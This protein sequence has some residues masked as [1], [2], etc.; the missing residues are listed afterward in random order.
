M[1][2]QNET[3]K[4]ERL[5]EQLSFLSSVEEFDSHFVSKDYLQGYYDTV[6]RDY[7]EVTQ[8]H[9]LSETV[10]LEEIGN[11]LELPLHEDPEGK[12]T[13]FYGPVNYLDKKV[14][15]A[16]RNRAER[17]RK[18]LKEQTKSDDFEDWVTYKVNNIYMNSHISSENN[19]YL[20]RIG[21]S[22]ENLLTK[23]LNSKELNEES[24]KVNQIISFKPKT[25]RL[26]PSQK[27]KYE[28][29]ETGDYF[30]D[31]V[32]PRIGAEFETYSRNT[33]KKWIGQDGTEQSKMFHPGD[34]KMDVIP[35]NSKPI[36]GLEY[37]RMMWSARNSR[38]FSTGPCEIISIEKG[39]IRTKI[40]PFTNVAVI[41]I[42]GMN[43]N[44]WKADLESFLWEMNLEGFEP[45]Y[46]IVHNKVTEKGHTVNIQIGWVFEKWVSRESAVKFM[47]WLNSRWN[48][49]SSSH[50][51][52]G[53]AKYII[54]NPFAFNSSDS[55]DE[56]SKHINDQDDYFYI[57][58][59]VLLPIREVM[60]HQYE[61]K[62]KGTFD[63]FTEE[64][65][66]VQQIQEEPEVETEPE[67][68]E[69]VQTPAAPAKTYYT[70]SGKR[71]RTSA[72]I[73]DQLRHLVSSLTKEQ[74]TDLY[75]QEYKKVKTDKTDH[76]L[77]YSAS[78]FY[79]TAWT[80]TYTPEQR[81][82]SILSRQHVASLWRN[83]L[84]NWIEEEGWNLR[85]WNFLKT[86]ERD[87]VIDQ[88]RIQVFR[89]GYVR[90]HDTVKRVF[91]SLLQENQSN[92]RMQEP[93][94]AFQS[95]D[96]LVKKPSVSST[97]RLPFNLSFLLNTDQERKINQSKKE[98]KE[99]IKSGQT[100][101]Y[102][103]SSFNPSFFLQNSRIKLTKRKLWL[104]GANSA[105]S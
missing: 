76:D 15:A 19:N 50:A 18:Q 67:P 24:K 96:I 35:D 34:R 36:T 33:K 77:A 62:A 10:D 46:V 103:P 47:D 95:L 73:A 83:H 60:E 5:P 20:F 42:D 70:P 57:F 31:M 4:K 75:I 32:Y 12:P 72:V 104:K 41:D 88:A 52:P 56:I 1:T 66:P 80:S 89:L 97:I 92:S 22:T 59:N 58:N 82:N 7:V 9:K 78:Y 38:S 28:F 68:K 81:R 98:K 48:E 61:K 63:E 105:C 51:D 17:K 94:I 44:R 6:S 29:Y 16:L 84:K 64:P 79:T 101:L 11:L 43:L 25:Q 69:I 71:K 74:W 65:A 13:K 23:N 8:R 30:T 3:E 53:F 86:T 27:R 26:K 90:K 54:K 49:F 2:E 39:K 40:K 21:T 87:R 45:T 91:L 55:I 93:S 102:T 37:I 85:L 14:Y 100:T 99:K